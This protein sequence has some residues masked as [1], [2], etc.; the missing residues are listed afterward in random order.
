MKRGTTGQ[1]RRHVDAA[2]EV[3]YDLV[4]D[5][6][7]MGEWSPECVGC[8]WIDGASGPAVGARFRGRNRHRLARWSTKP[9]VTVANRPSELAFVAPDGF[10]RDLTIWWYRLEPAGSGTELTESFELLRDIPWYIRAWRRSFMGV[11]DRKAD[12]EENMGRTLSN[13]KAAAEGE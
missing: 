3:V 10:G 2:P 1:V 13:I 12:L 7:R 9:R 5:V 4:A 6:S 11:K 8:D